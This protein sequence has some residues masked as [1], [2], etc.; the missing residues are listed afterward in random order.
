MFRTSLTR[1]QERLQRD[2]RLDHVHVARLVRI[3]GASQRHILFV[4]TLKIT[5]SMDPPLCSYAIAHHVFDK[6]QKAMRLCLA[7]NDPHDRVQKLKVEPLRTEAL[8]FE[9]GDYKHIDELPLMRGYI[10]ELKFGFSS[11]RMG[12]GQHARMQAT[13]TN[14][15]Y[16]TEAFDSIGR[17]L[18][19]IKQLLENDENN[20][21]QLASILASSRNPKK[22]VERIGM[23]QHPSASLG[24]TP[25]DPIYAKLVYR[26]DPYSQ[27]HMPAP[28][29]NARPPS[30]PPLSPI[31][32]Q[33]GESDGAPPTDAI[34]EPGESP[35][36]RGV[37][38]AGGQPPAEA[39][40]TPEGDGSST[41]AIAMP[42]PAPPGLQMM[43][44]GSVQAALNYYPDAFRE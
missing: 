3:F 16:H 44:S 40:A 26:A 5:P 22:C 24:E 4:M 35:A 37:G 42:P 33:A 25:W 27:Q 9:S 29:I 8:L 30:P 13:T 28:N 7:S 31:M 12:E 38:P 17:R 23:S 20:A 32:D 1:L 19:M 18:P 41:L 34:G 36:E 39:H 21:V 2:T 10:G 14:A 15:P 43:K 11:E 6:A